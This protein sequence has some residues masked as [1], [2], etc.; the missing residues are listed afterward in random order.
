MAILLGQGP[1][2]SVF[3]VQRIV[4]SGVKEATG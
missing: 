1:Q 2:G 4:L 3:R